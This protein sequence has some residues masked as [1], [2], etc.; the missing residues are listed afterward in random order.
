MVNVF[1][2]LVIWLVVAVSGPLAAFVASYL[3]F[4][5]R[6]AAILGMA[7][8]ALVAVSGIF[9]SGSKGEWWLALGAILGAVTACIYLYR[10][11]IRQPR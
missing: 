2:A 3:V 7:A 6:R 9:S 11:E 8:A 1:P 4:D 5:E 10:K